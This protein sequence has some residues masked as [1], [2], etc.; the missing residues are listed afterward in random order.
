MMT[1]RSDDAPR[2]LEEAAETFREADDEAA[3]GTTWTAL[4]GDWGALA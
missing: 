1:K 2:V 3:T 4:D